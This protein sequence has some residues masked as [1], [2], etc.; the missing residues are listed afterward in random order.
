M[1]VQ[2]S[3]RRTRDPL[4]ALGRGRG[5]TGSYSAQSASALAPSFSSTIR[6]PPATWGRH[7][8]GRI[9]YGGATIR[10]NK[11]THDSACLRSASEI[12]TPQSF[13]PPKVPPR[14]LTTNRWTPPAPRNP[15]AHS[16]GLQGLTAVL[17]LLSPS[18]AVVV[19]VA[20]R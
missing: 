20:L 4:Q 3:V 8:V 6:S 9:G 1:G 19:I 2:A 16:L 7:R 17:E 11:R 15:I 10:I 5:Q 13:L 14:L 12:A 18:M